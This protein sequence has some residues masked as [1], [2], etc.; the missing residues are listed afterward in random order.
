MNQQKQFIYK[1]KNIS[2]YVTPSLKG[3]LSMELDQSRE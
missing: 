3:T 2:I 1:N